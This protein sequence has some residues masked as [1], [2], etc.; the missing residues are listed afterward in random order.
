[1]T[2]VKQSC[3][4]TRITLWTDLFPAEWKKTYKLNSRQRRKTKE[5]TWPFLTSGRLYKKQISKEQ[6]K[7]AQALLNSQGTLEKSERPLLQESM[8]LELPIDLEDNSLSNQDQTSSSIITF[9]EE[10]L[11]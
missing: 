6:V 9:S 2:S 5:I 3:F 1:M 10:F 8:P 4:P 7:R 11:L